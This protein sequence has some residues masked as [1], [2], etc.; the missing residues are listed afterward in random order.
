MTG[1]TEKVLVLTQ[2]LI[3]NMRSALMK[4]VF[5]LFF[6]FDTLFKR[7]I[8]KF[9][10]NHFIKHFQIIKRRVSLTKIE[11]NVIETAGRNTLQEPKD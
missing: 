10:S 9:I 1:I 8:I 11:N 2:K 3:Y 5:R 6:F 4:K 7:K